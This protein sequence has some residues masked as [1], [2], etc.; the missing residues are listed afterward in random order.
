MIHECFRVVDM[1]G[2]V[3]NLFPWVRHFSPNKSGYKPLL[4]AHKPL[5]SFLRE[6]VNE[7]RAKN[8]NERPKSFI[9]S[10]LEELTN[11][12][13]GEN[14]HS[15]FSGMFKQSS[16]KWI[17]NFYNTNLLHSAD[18]QLLSICLDFFQAGTETT[19]N[20]LSFGLMYMIHNR[21]ICDQVQAELDAVIGQKR[22]ANLQDR[23]HLPYVEAVLSEILRFSNVAP[24]GIAHRTTENTRFK[25]HIIPKD[26]VILMSLYSLNMD[27]DYWHDPN[28]FRPERFLNENGEYIPHTE[29]FFPFGLGKRRCM[30]ENLAKNSLFLYFATFM[31]AFNMIVPN[32]VPLPNIEPNDG[33]TLQPKP[34]Q[35]Q[36][37]PRF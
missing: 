11:K 20:T 37:K 17:S 6:V 22:F 18:E 29:Q 32:N 2:G 21:R 7:N 10:Y 36:L 28:V 34:F 25:E 4:E 13:N 12:S 9:N 27:K 24:L 19:S 16:K 14:I 15:S 35:L 33:I 30:G 26:T 8:S 23:N 5:W 3:L 1:T 31:H